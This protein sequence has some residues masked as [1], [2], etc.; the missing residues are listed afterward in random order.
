MTS[1]SRDIPVIDFEPYMRGSEAGKRQVA[2][3]IRDAAER[4]GFFYVAHPPV[5]AELRC[6]AFEQSAAF[7]ALPLS[8]KNKVAI[9][10]AHRGYLP[11]ASSTYS[12][13]VRPN[14]NESFLI[15]VDLP[16]DDPDVLAGTPMH[17]SNQW[18]PELPEHRR[19]MQAYF[20]AMNRFGRDLL[21]AAA[22]ALDL[23]EAFFDA[24]YKKPMT[25]VRCAHYPSQT[26]D[27]PD[28]EFGSATH[29]DHGCLTLLAQ[30]DVGGLQVQRRDGGWID[31]QPLPGTY[32][33]NIGDMLMRWTNDRWVSTPHR[34]IN[35]SGRSRLSIPF[36]Y[37][38]SFDTRVE[39]IPSCLR[40]GDRPRYEP[41]T[42]GEHFTARFNQAY[43]YRKVAA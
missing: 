39:C 19:V 25:F 35:V 30:D 11:V 41:I 36:F 18:L 3:A 29:S 23:P 33:V 42:W 28:N 5:S 32:V 4:I 16:A 27:R 40:P 9:N 14:V 17:G 20:E 26:V 31:A 43:D 1:N 21:R 6:S 24:A 34:V 10:K 7:F 8:Q 2:A 22:L 38:P 37:N 15:G 12:A 13:T